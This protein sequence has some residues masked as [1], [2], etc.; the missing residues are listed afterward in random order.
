MYIATQTIAGG[1]GTFHPGD[2][3]DNDIHPDV[4]D[5]WLAAGIIEERAAVAEEAPAAKPAKPARKA[6]AKPRFSTTPT[7]QRRFV[8]DATAPA[9]ETATTGPKG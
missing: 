7:P 8:E 5:A 9:P 3:I 4:R 1:F 6:P 2:E